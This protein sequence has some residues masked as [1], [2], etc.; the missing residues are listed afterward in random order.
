[1][2]ETKRHTQDGDTGCHRQG[3]AFNITSLQDWHEHLPRQTAPPALVE[4]ES[5]YWQH[6]LNILLIYIDV[7]I[8]GSL[9]YWYGPFCAAHPRSDH[10]LHL[11]PVS[12]CWSHIHSHTHINTHTHIHTHT[13]THIQSMGDCTE[14]VE[15]RFNMKTEETVV[16]RCRAQWDKHTDHLF[17]RQLTSFTLLCLFHFLPPCSPSSAHSIICLYSS[18]TPGKILDPQV[19][20]LISSKLL[21]FPQFLG[22]SSIRVTWHLFWIIVSFMFVS[23]VCVTIYFVYGFSLFISIPFGNVLDQVVEK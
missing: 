9:E 23:Q 18:K 21:I 2:L 11:W 17:Y 16:R 10:S 5:Q 4:A 20:M 1:M 6:K 3:A 12:S 22:S 8:S 7:H 15:K 13:N 14:I 19:C